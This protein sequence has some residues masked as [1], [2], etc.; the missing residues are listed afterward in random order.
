MSHLFILLTSSSEAFSLTLKTKLSSLN[1]K[2]SVGM[3][4][5]RKI[6]MPSL[7]KHW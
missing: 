7:N 1:L 3:K 2:F 5:S 6:L 4:P